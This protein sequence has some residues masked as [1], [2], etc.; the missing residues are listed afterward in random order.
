LSEIKI[1]VD[2]SESTSDKVVICQE[3]ADKLGIKNGAS[4]EVHNPD[5]GKKITAAIE[6]SN[7]VLDFA[8][9]VSKNIVDSLDFMGIELI[10]RPMSSTGLVTPK[11]QA[12]KVLKPA[13]FVAS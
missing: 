2:V 3:N 1:F 6:I 13:G 11:I 4:I 5:N 12:P 7:M 8:G 9:Q 10:L